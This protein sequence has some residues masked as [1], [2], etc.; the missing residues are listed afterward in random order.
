[1]CT[2]IILSK[3]VSRKLSPI[4]IIKRSGKELQLSKKIQVVVLFNFVVEA[5]LQIS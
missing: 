4:K 2:T 5:K 1:M 3:S